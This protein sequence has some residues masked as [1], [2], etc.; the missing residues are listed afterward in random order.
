[1]SLICHFQYINHT[2]NSTFPPFSIFDYPALAAGGVGVSPAQTAQGNIDKRHFAD[3]AQGAG[4]TPTPPA[5]AAGYS[6]TI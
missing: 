6:T 2:H 5:L 1:M 3:G 4:E